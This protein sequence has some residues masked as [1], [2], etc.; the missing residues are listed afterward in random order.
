M[1]KPIAIGLL[2]LV[3]SGGAAAAWRLWPSA[4]TAGQRF[5]GYVEAEYVR[6]SPTQPGLLVGLNVARGEVVAA[7]ALLFA[8]DEI[9]DR[10]A[11]DEAAM[12]LGQAEA[13]LA[14]LAKGGRPSEIEAA[15]AAT[16]DAR[17]VRERAE[18]D[19]HRIEPLVKE[20][21]ASRQRLDQLRAEF[22]QA[23]AQVTRA[24]ANEATV[25]AAARE[26]E[27]VAQRAAVQAARATLAQAE[28][29]L[30]QRRVAAPAGGLVADTMF[31]PGEHVAAG[32]PVVTLL[33]PENLLVRFYAPEP[34]LTRLAPGTA[35]QVT[36][37]GCA[38]TLAFRVSFVATRAEYTP[39][40]IY[41]ETTR[42]KLLYLIEARPE[43][44][45]APL[46]TGQPV[47]V[48]LEQPR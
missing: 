3:V 16:R 36:C 26:D 4:E 7:G 18:A 30:A 12:K 1:R 38:D 35:L 47:T 2:A 29:R 48:A 14:N 40:V 44:L 39:P 46:R 8:Q 6:V 9:G 34:V 11:R 42:G 21:V 5:Q 15:A 19:L 37:D 13:Q 22:L 45:P 31:R 33:P 20:G 17:A 24:E 27:I 43:R 25:R 10:A 41:S 23:Q 32:Y 28:W